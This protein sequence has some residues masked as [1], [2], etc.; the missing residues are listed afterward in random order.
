M[1]KKV[2][3]NRLDKLERSSTDQDDY[4]LIISWSSTDGSTDPDVIHVSWSDILDE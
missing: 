2:T 4:K 3:D 1:A